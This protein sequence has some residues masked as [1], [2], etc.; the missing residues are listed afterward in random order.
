MGGIL[1]WVLQEIGAK[2]EIV[3]WRLTE[4]EG[5]QTGQREK[6]DHSAVSTWALAY[7]TW[8]FGVGIAL[9]IEALGCYLLPLPSGDNTVFDLLSCLEVGG[10]RFQKPLVGLPFCKSS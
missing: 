5:N 4:N 9:Q 1:S 6:L 2:A 8:S 3:R 10:Q 7:S